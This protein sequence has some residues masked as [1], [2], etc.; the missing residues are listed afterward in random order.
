[1]IALHFDHAILDRATRTALAAQLLAQQGQ[2]HSIK[3]QAFHHRD[4][5]AATALGLA[6]YAHLAVTGRNGF[7]RALARTLG[8]RLAAAWANAA[9]FGGIDESAQGTAFHDEVRI[10]GKAAIVAS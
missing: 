2:R 4:A 10:E 7:G 8:H 1:M 9:R 5:L 3:R 6:R